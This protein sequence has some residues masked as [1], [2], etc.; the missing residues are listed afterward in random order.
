MHKDTSDTQFLSNGF[1]LRASPCGILKSF[2]YRSMF[3]KEK[4]K[5]VGIPLTV[6]WLDLR[7]STPRRERR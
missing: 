5:Q 3:T 7:T 4:K 1:Q 2:L 6:Q